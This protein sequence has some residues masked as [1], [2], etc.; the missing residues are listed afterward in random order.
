MTVD[1]LHI[2]L[3]HLPAILVFIGWLLVYVF[4]ALFAMAGV[5][6]AI[7]WVMGLLHRLLTRMTGRAR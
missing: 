5:V 4:Y 6:L 7:D 1:Q 3:G 2:A